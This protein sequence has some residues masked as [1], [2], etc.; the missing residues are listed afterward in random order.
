[1]NLELLNKDIPELFPFLET[2][3]QD[4]GLKKYSIEGA[5]NAFHFQE[6]MSGFR[7]V[8]ADLEA[9]IGVGILFGGLGFVLHRQFKS[10]SIECERFDHF[11]YNGKFTFTADDKS[12][13][14]LFVDTMEMDLSCPILNH[15]YNFLSLEY[16]HAGEGKTRI[17]EQVYAIEQFLRRIYKS[18]N[19]RLPIQTGLSDIAF[20][21]IYNKILKTEMDPVL[22]W[23][24]RQLVF[25]SYRDT[26]K[27]IMHTKIRAHKLSKNKFYAALMRRN[28]VNFGERVI[29]RPVNNLLGLF[30]RYTIGKVIWFFQTVKNNLGYSVA[31]AVYGPF[32]YYFITMPMNPHA[33]QAVGKVRSVYLDAK[34][35]ILDIWE[36]TAHSGSISAQTAPAKKIPEPAAAAS[37]EDSISTKNAAPAMETKSL[38]NIIYQSPV[39]S[40]SVEELVVELGDGVKEKVRPTFLNMLLTTDIQKVDRQSW[41]E[42]MSRFKQMQIAYEENIEY[43]SRMGRLEQ[44]ETQYNF[45]MQVENAWEE[46]ERYNNLIFRLREENP[47]MS[48]KMKQYLF[49]EI[50]RT[51]QLQLY[52]WDRM[53]R[54]ILDQIYVMLDQDNEQK[55]NNYY[56]GRSFVFMQEMTN[57]LS[58]RYKDFKKHEGHERIEKLAN[59]YSKS[60]KEFGSVTQNLRENSDLFKQKDVLNTKEFRAYMKRQWEIL[61]LQNA[62][63]EE[64]SNNGLNMYIWS[65]RNTVWILQSIYSSKREELAMLI[66]RDTSGQALSSADGLTRSKISLLYETLIHN[67]T[68]EYVGIREEIMNRLGKDIESTQRM[69]VLDNLKEFLSDREKLDGL[70]IADSQK[71]A[72]TTI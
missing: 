6:E 28:I 9:T 45:P 4:G 35:E 62:K 48:A 47:N 69:M 3:L 67:L 33:M 51:H 50:N 14:A 15:L 61:F 68:L 24:E 42:R 26:L 49:N 31:L 54:F 70:N 44:L 58:W 56:V 10:S 59:F 41:N 66:K 29:S 60:R 23:E 18:K 21:H 53:G 5:V 27:K 64:A 65:V 72:G 52:L 13:E 43:A 1:M 32:T 46:L 37:D 25:N 16:R 19:I 8:T 36:M 63:A 71:A 30:Y 34:T 38:S 39:T 55:R 2:I 57:I 12:L 17:T 11:D 22:T 20:T 40:N 7:Y